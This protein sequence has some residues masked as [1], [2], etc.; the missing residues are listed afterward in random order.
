EAFSVY[1]N[2]LLVCTET[3]FMILITGQYNVT[4][5][6]AETIVENIPGVDYTAFTQYAIAQE[7]PAMG[8]AFVAIALFCFAFTTIIAYYYMAETNFAYLDKKNRYFKYGKWTIAAMVLF[9]TYYG[10]VK[11]ADAAW[12]LGD[13][14]V[15]SMAWLNLIAILILRKPA[16]KA[17]K[18]YRAQKK[19]GKDPHFNPT[20]LGIKSADYWEKTERGD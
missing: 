17:L 15:G 4:P 20:E 8:K 18:D 5:I 10:A 19:A 1:V 2:T 13:I 11:T 12:T 6:G 16:L 3:A 14:G 9:S 7:F